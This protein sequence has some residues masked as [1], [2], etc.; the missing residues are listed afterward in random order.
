MGPMLPCAP[1]DRPEGAA[2]KAPGPN[3]PEIESA[4]PHAHPRDPPEYP[5]QSHPGA[6]AKLTVTL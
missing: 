2:L 1:Q 3:P 4:S 5:K 6:D